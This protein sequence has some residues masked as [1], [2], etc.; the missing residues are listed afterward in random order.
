MYLRS[1]YIALTYTVTF[2]NLR[3]PSSL[4]EEISST[5][6]KGPL[7][8][9]SERHTC[10]HRTWQ[11]VLKT[12]GWKFKKVRTLNS[13]IYIKKTVNLNAITS[14]QRVLLK[15][16]RVPNEACLL[17]NSDKNLFIPGTFQEESHGLKLI[18]QHVSN[19]TNAPLHLV[20][21]LLLCE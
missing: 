2:L 17:P 6:G 4:G 10:K 16:Y 19:N 9:F 5:V 1:S 20:L 15:R 3:A 8:L 21:S 11:L 18:C 7:F 14:P 13:F 12:S